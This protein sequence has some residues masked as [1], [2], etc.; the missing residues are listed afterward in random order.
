MT[1][2]FD[3][4]G[5]ILN[6]KKRYISV[7]KESLE[8]V[9]KNSKLNIN[10]WFLKRKGK[11][12][13]SIVPFLSS[14]Q[15]KE[16]Q[17]YRLKFLEDEKYLGLD[18]LNPSVIKMLKNLKGHVLILATLRKDRNLLLEQLKDLNLVDYF[19]RR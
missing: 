9:F 15:F 18:T 2:F 13:K 11:L 8:L 17:E 12:E 14:V 7:A 16:Y 6:I 19:M 3:L 4:D 10:Y 5:T 1:I